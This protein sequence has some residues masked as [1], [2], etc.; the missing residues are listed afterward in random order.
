MRLVLSALTLAALS[1]ASACKGSSSSSAPASVRFLPADPDTAFRIDVPRLRA[2]SVYPQ[3]SQVALVSVEML[4]KGATEK[5]GLDVMGT[6]TTIIGAKKSSLMSGDVTLIVAGLPRDKVTACLDTVASAKSMLELVRDGDVF[7]ANVQGR[8][9]ASGA[10][11]S[12]GE[13]V[14]VARKGSGVEPAQWKTEV[15][16]G[17]KAVPA[18]WTELEP[19]FE[20]PIAVRAADDKR[21][22]LA[23]A[24]FSDALTVRAKVVTKSDADAKGDVTRINAILAYLKS[25]SAGDGKAEAQG[26]NA[27]AEITAKGSEALALIKTGGGALFTRNAELPTQPATASRPYQCSELS[28]A[29]GDYMNAALESAG[30]SQQMQDMVTTITPPLKEAYVDACTEGKWADAAIECHVINATNLPKFEKCR[31]QLSEA[32]RGPFDEKVAAVLSQVAPKEP[33]AGSGSAEK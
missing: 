7:H 25:A 26:T 6:A 24:S 9:I 28:Q 13:V 3:L 33:A 11:L 19:F 18:W 2:W 30:R 1:T 12:T 23:T 15:D 20:H 14:V 10:L 29:V 4:L 31:V 17:A 21:T 27:Y 32:Q 22:V 16:A 8:S 5:C